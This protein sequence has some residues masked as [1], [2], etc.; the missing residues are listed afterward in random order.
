MYFAENEHRNLRAT[1]PHFF[2]KQFLN[3]EY[4][5]YMEQLLKGSLLERRDLLI[6]H[7][8]D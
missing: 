5:S 1:G 8:L 4:Q 6:Y 3:K 7:V 2:N